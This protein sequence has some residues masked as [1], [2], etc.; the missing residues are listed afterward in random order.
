MASNMANAIGFLTAQLLAMRSAWLQK[1]RDIQ[2]AL[3]LRLLR[4]K[5]AP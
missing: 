4:C 1:S 2:N 5:S 3:H